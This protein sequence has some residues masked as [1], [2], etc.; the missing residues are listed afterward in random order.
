MIVIGV[1]RK[2]YTRKVLMYS[3][4]GGWEIAAP[5][6]KQMDLNV[7]VFFEALNICMFVVGGIFRI[8]DIMY[9]V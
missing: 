8:I 2:V 5:V 6:H 1:I 4:N 3:A 9:I 7:H